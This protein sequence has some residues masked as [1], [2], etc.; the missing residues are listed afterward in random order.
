MYVYAARSC[1]QSIWIRLIKECNRIRPSVQIVV[2]LTRISN[3]LRTGFID[4]FGIYT[5]TQ[6]NQI[7]ITYIKTIL[8]NNGPLGRLGESQSPHTHFTRIFPPGSQRVPKNLTDSSI[9]T[10]MIISINRF[11]GEINVWTTSR[12]H[13]NI[14]SYLRLRLQYIGPHWYQHNPKQCILIRT[15][16]MSR[17]CHSQQS[18]F[19]F[20]HSKQQSE[21]LDIFPLTHTSQLPLYPLF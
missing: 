3:V 11:S 21:N 15:T 12:I 7:V 17:E 16:S 18:R 14:K 13:V 1:Q 8:A 9:T 6:T 5:P 4:V 19:L 10:N 20:C 2:Y